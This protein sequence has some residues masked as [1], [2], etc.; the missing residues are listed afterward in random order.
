MPV[1]D[2]F[3]TE[4]VGN[5][6]DMKRYKHVGK[7]EV[8]LSVQ[9]LDVHV[10]CDKTRLFTVADG[11]LFIY[12]FNLDEDEWHATHKV[13]VMVLDPSP[14]LKKIRVNITVIYSFFPNISKVTVKHI[15]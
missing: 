4:L 7:S 5:R 6:Q 2:Q 3:L 14:E 10:P 8:V 9:V 13:R 11:T 1:C 15:L 12:R